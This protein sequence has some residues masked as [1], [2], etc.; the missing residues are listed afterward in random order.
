MPAPLSST[1]YLDRAFQE[2]RHHSLAFSLIRREAN[3]DLAMHVHLTPQLL[4]EADSL[5]K[6][7]SLKM[8]KL[9]NTLSPENYNMAQGLLE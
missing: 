8:Q 4:I 5:L 3:S 7:A 6:D 1:R 2:S 9:G